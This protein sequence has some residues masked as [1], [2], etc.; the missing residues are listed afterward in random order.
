MLEDIQNPDFAFR[1]IVRV[2]KKFYI[3]TP[4]PL[5]EMLRGVDA[6]P[7]KI[8]RGYIHHRYLIWSDHEKNILYCLPKYPIVEHLEIESDFEQK[9]IWVANHQD[10]HWN[11]YWL[12]EESQEE[13]SPPRVVI[14]S[15]DR[16]YKINQSSYGELIQQGILCCLQNNK[17]FVE[18]L[19]CSSK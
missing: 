13:G 14:L 17:K 3:E 7:P 12:W 5:I 18:K 9:M 11:H 19:F 10:V 16:D 6:C 4:S 2:S 1:K 8:H 15:H